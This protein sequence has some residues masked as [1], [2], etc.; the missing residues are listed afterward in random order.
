ML[1]VAVGGSNGGAGTDSTWN[2]TDMIAKK[3][4][5]ASGGTGRNWR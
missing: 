1:L 4:N 5:A 3:G 2:T